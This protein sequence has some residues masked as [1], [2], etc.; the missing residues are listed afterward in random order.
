MRYLVDR[1]DLLAREEKWRGRK[2]W[3]QDMGDMGGWDG[4]AAT[5]PTDRPSPDCSPCV[6]FT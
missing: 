1:R 4:C 5:R 3:N 6:L 2:G